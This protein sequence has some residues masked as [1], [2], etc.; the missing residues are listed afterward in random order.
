MKGPTTSANAARTTKSVPTQVNSGGEESGNLVGDPKVL[1][2]K[3]PLT[4][5]IGVKSGSNV[6]KK[7]ST[8]LTTQK[9]AAENTTEQTIDKTNNLEAITTTMQSTTNS[10][11]ATSTNT[12]Q[13]RKRAASNDN[14]STT[15][16]K[17][18]PRKPRTVKKFVDADTQTTNVPELTS[19]INTNSLDR[20][21]SF[22]PEFRECED[23][24]NEEINYL[25]ELLITSLE[26]G[27]KI[28]PNIRKKIIKEVG[29]TQNINNDDIRKF[30]EFLRIYARK[31]RTFL[32]QNESAN[33]TNITCT[34]LPRESIAINNRLLSTIVTTSD[35]DET[36]VSN[37]ITTVARNNTSPLDSIKFLPII[38]NENQVVEYRPIHVRNHPLINMSR[39]RNILPK[40]IT[41]VT[42]S[43]SRTSEG[44]AIHTTTTASSSSCNTLF[45]GLMNLNRLHGAQNIL[46][47]VCISSNLE[48]NTVI[49]LL[50]CRKL[51]SQ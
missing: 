44:G 12:V 39:F 30:E 46:P 3:I 25:D 34:H 16:R 24:L 42:T 27:K 8:A 50:I 51:L 15:T 1:I 43:T 31:A 2:S 26:N 28:N 18:A 22:T 35:N 37:L 5:L 32:S 29:K 38:N 48:H 40:P 4:N 13:S 19:I 20:T 10:D 49:N 9:D 45:N 47:P 23:L 11:V 36:N 7:T 21:N 33:T 17:R 6:N 41:T 14:S